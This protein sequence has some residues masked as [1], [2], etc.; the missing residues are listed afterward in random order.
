MGHHILIVEDEPLIA[1]DIELT[2]ENNHYECVGKA[3]TSTQALDMLLNRSPDIVLLDISIKGDKDGIM[4]AEII[5]AKYRIPFIFITSYS[6]AIT[7]ERAKHTLPYGYIVKPFKDK[8]LLATIEMAMYRYS[9]ENNSNSLDKLAIESKFKLKITTMEYE[10]IKLIWEGKSNIT[11]SN[12]L[13]VSI[14]TVKTHVRNVFEKFDVKSRNEMIVLL[15][16]V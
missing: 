14:N 1:D 3:Y 4:I 6:D 11:I 10:V 13:Y 5:R 15:R 12:V 7:L 2:L 16:Q 9:K 8:D